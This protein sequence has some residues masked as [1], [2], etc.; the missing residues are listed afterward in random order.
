MIAQVTVT[1]VIHDISW[2]VT[3]LRNHLIGGFRAALMNGVQYI[4]T[5]HE[6]E[7]KKKETKNKI[8][9]DLS[10]DHFYFL[11]KTY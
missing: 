9:L 11:L 8:Q 2:N 6:K 1:V 5:G 4:L 3:V 7:Q 10:S